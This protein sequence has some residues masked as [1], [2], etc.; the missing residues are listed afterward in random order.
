MGGSLHDPLAS[1]PLN[2]TPKAIETSVHQRDCNTCAECGFRSGKYMNVHAPGRGPHRTS[3][4]RTLCNACFDV[5]CLDEAVKMRSVSFSWI[6]EIEQEEL[7]RLMPNLYVARIGNHGPL[8]KRILDIIFEERRELAR[9]K[10]PYT[11][12]GDLVKAMEEGADDA[13]LHRFFNEGLRILPLDRRI[14]KE[15]KME[16][17][18]FPQILAYWRS[19]SGPLN[20]SADSFA[21]IAQDWLRRLSSN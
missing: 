9:E 2:D 11:E 17:N 13:Q 10:I 8:T 21:V 19:R 6:P 18:Q 16:F 5:V 20:G 15:G 4:Y 14:I 3:A 1:L 12:V 7:N